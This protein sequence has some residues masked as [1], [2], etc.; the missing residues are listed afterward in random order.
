MQWFNKLAGSAERLRELMELEKDKRRAKEDRRREEQAKGRAFFGDDRFKET[1][2][3]DV[4]DYT[5]DVCAKK[6]TAHF[7]AVPDLF[8]ECPECQEETKRWTEELK[9]DLEAEEAGSEV[10]YS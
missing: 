3:G 9:A 7:L 6:F 2:P 4:Q 10:E 1:G 5:C 8:P